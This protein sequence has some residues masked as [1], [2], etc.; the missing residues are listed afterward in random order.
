MQRYLNSLAILFG[1]LFTS[2]L[3]LADSG[4]IEAVNDTRRDAQNRARDSARHPEQTL[5][6]FQIEPGMR[7]AEIWPGRGWYTEILA[8]WLKQGDGHL[9]AAGFPADMGPDWR[10]QL[11]NSYNDWLSSDTTRFDEVEIIEFGPGHW[12]ITQ[13]NSLDAIVTFRN[14]H[15]WVK[16]E[17]AEAA[18]SA[19]FEA[20][21][22]GGVLGV[23]D[24]RAKPGTDRETM[25]KTGYLT[26]SLVIGLAEQAGFKL[27]ATSE[28]NAN[29]ADTTRHPN[30]VWSLPPTL[31]IA[32]EDKAK[33]QAIGES[34]RMTLRFI[35]PQNISLPDG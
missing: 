32:D 24:H 9:I 26:E 4:L 7:V 23:T 10:Q 8:P 14:V 12:Q 29:P 5:A 27:D 6:F 2:P 19:M 30:G 15:N 22:P 28:I 21:K 17:T 35:K 20:L 3:V 1:L 25:K 33:Y 13:A 11:R 31:R 18:F 34:D 16:A